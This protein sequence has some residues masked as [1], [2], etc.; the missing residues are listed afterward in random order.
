MR[1]TLAQYTNDIVGLTI[2]ALMSIAF[3]AGQAG[4]VQH[5]ASE[6]NDVDVAHV[7]VIDANLDFR[8]ENLNFRQEGE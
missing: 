5:V 6:V 1:A 3:I 2:M 7:L 4:A 8:Q